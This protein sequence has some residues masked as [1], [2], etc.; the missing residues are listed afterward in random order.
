MPSGRSP[1]WGK[2]SST[3]NPCAS[4]ACNTRAEVS[5]RGGNL[6]EGRPSSI[7]QQIAEGKAAS[8]GRV[9]L[10][11]QEAA[12][13]ADI[14]FRD[15]RERGADEE[16]LGPVRA[17]A[18]RGSFVGVAERAA[19]GFVHDTAD[20][21]LHVRMAEGNAK[22]KEG[23][24][25]FIDRAIRRRAILGKAERIPNRGTEARVTVAW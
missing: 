20:K 23:R 3:L 2:N 22:C 10:F 11:L 15:D 7:G 9:L 6:C 25:I 24:P 17:I 8:A 18:Q 1:A 12:R 13:V 16:V 5:S 19:G 21:R 4:L 14:A